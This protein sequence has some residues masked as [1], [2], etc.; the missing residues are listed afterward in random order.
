MSSKTQP[1]SKLDELF[2]EEEL[3]EVEERAEALR[4]SMKLAAIRHE[5]ALTQGDVAKI[6]G[7]KQPT[8]SNLEQSSESAK[9]ETIQRYVKALGGK[10]SIDIEIDGKH[11]HLA[12]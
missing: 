3:I 1:L 10:M 12:T 7:V 8:V 9:L 4:V 2:T 11:F 6:M 5:V